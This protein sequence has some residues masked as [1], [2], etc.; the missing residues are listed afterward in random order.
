M[1]SLGLAY[2]KKEIIELDG[3]PESHRVLRDAAAARTDGFKLDFM[4]Y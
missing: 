4:M 3:E 1:K 2:F